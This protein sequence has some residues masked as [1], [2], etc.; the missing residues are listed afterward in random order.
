[1]LLTHKPKVDIIN[2]DKFNKFS[3]GIFLASRTDDCLSFMR[4]VLGIYI[5]K[6]LQQEPAHGNKLAEEIRQRTQNAYTPNTNALYPLLRRMEEKGYIVGEWDSPVRR[7]KRIYTIT[8]AGLGRIPAL[9][10]MLAERL[11]HLEWK[12]SV[13]REDLLPH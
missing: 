1:M 3:E 2:N 12:I 10:T 7:N 8:A 11:K 9:E 4:L 6:I 5:L 13:L